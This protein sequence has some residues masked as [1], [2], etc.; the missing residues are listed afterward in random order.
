MGRCVMKFHAK[1]LRISVADTEAR[2]RP[3]PGSKRFKKG[4]E[5]S[6]PLLHVGPGYINSVSRVSPPF[7]WKYLDSAR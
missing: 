3:D 7:F 5:L 4:D 1:F 2:S 6:L